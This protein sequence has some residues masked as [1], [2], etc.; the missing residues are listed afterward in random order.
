MQQQLVAVSRGFRGLTGALASVVIP[1][2]CKVCKAPLKTASRIPVCER[3]LGSLQRIQE[4]IC[5]RCGRPFLSAVAAQV[6]NPQCRLC[7]QGRYAF[8]LA[9]SFAIYDEILA[10]LVILLKHQA[11]R[12]LGDWCANRLVE[13]LAGT[14]R[15]AEAD[16]IVPVPLHPFRRKERGYNQAEW[17]ARPLARRLGIA[18]EPC[19]LV[20]IKP[21][22]PR[23]KLT[24]RERWDSVRGAYETTK[25]AKVDNLR[26]LLVD[27]V[28]TTG[29]TLDACA[30]ALR[31]EGAAQ[32]TAVTVGRVVFQWIPH[33]K[34]NPAT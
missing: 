7:R 22:P 1:G 3:C 2:S 27:D 33:P 19:L 24:R 21:R 6:E 17:I 4:G 13:L 15:L 5:G 34:E 11:V 30:R 26:V 31:G 29:A 23:L 20:R 18:F 28:F 16:L 10:R 32:V 14:P 8:D 25:G 12:P 9:R